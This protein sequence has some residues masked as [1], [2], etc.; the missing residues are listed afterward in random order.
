MKVLLE[1]SQNSIN[2][3]KHNILRNK[4]EKSQDDLANIKEKNTALLSEIQKL[5]CKE[6]FFIVVRPLS[7][8][9][10]PPLASERELDEKNTR[11]RIME[12]EMVEIQLELEMIKK[13]LEISDPHFKKYTQAIQKLVDIMTR[14]NISPM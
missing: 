5:K 2:K 13:M 11:I 3:S 1:E 14:N 10:P 6:V 7:P 8:P 4:F 12:D 9:L